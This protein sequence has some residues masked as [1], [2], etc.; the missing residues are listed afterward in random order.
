[1]DDQDD[2]YARALRAAEELRGR[3]GEHEVALVLGSGWAEACDGLGTVVDEMPASELTGVA[4]PTVQGH[5]GVLRS[6]QVPRADRD[7]LSLLVLAGRSHLYEGHDVA[8]VVHPIRAA[9]RSGCARVV[10]TNAAG[11][12]RPEWGVGSPVMLADHL[13]L[14]GSNPMVGA[15]PSGSWGPRF[16]DLSQLYAPWWRDE[17]ARR[18]P[19]MPEGVYAG[20]LGGSFETPAE[21]RMLGTLGADLV[22][23]STVLEA[24][25]ARH[26]GAEVLGLS[27]VTNLAAGLQ[28]RIDHLEVL[29]AADAAVDTL[30]DTLRAALDAV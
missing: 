28:E 5:S 18:R 3:L 22:G 19:G 26:A 15:G 20:L 29:D 10:L 30:A 24:I 4:A 12:L 21:I 2:P 14:T 9:V 7:P 25:A 8:T 6:M 13:N 17:L 27:L 23:M 16:V 1:V 11:S